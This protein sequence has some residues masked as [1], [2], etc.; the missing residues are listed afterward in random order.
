MALHKRSESRIVAG[1]GKTM[2]QL[3][4]GQIARLLDSQ[5]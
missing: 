5:R 1:R 3:V 4:I 2:D